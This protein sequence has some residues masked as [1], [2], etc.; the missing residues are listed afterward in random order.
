MTINRKQYLLA[1]EYNERVRSVELVPFDI[2][3]RICF[4]FYAM[5]KST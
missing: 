2:V 5:T 1:R 4:I 3:T